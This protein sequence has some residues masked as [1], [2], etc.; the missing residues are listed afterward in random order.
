MISLRPAPSAVVVDLASG[1]RSYA[2]A[3]TQ[4]MATAFMTDPISRWIF[5]LEAD[6]ERLHPG[7]FRIFVDMVLADGEAYTTRDRTGVTMWL[8]VDA[9]EPAQSDDDFRKMFVTSCGESA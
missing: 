3:L 6:R 7:F 1:P 9:T 4:I 8:N 2:A 5:P